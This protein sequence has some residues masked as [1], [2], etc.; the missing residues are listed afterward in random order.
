MKIVARKT[1][2]AETAAP[3]A[4]DLYD[5]AKQALVDSP[6]FGVSCRELKQRHPSDLDLIHYNRALARAA[7]DLGA[8]A[9]WTMVRPPCDGTLQECRYRLKPPAEEPQS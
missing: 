3:P 1:R 2:A 8:K 4:A 7:K 5:L 9:S 6:T